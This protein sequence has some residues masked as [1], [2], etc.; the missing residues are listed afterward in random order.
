[1]NTTEIDR[2][3]KI[4][5]DLYL[6]ALKK[7]HARGGNK[8]GESLTSHPYSLSYY[9]NGVWQGIGIGGNKSESNFYRERMT[10][11]KAASTF[12]YRHGMPKMMVM[13]IRVSPKRN[14]LV[15]KYIDG[16]KSDLLTMEQEA[17][18]LARVYLPGL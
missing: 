16:I 14:R 6:M 13:N 4:L 7:L 12:I 18:I 11:D 2:E 5:N 3:Q 1:M 17:K 9:D 8:K 15:W 10:A